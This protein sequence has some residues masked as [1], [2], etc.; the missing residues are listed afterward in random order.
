[1]RQLADEARLD[2][3]VVLLLLANVEPINGV[4]AAAQKSADQDYQAFLDA[5]G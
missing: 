5:I 1:M 2:G 3:D 4:R